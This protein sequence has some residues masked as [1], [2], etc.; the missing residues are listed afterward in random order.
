MVWTLAGEYRLPSP[1]PAFTVDLLA[2]ARMLDL[3][4][5]LGWNISGSLGPIDPAART[6]SA[7]VKD[8]V[9][10]ALIGVKGRYVFGGN[11]QWAVPFYLDVGT[12][13]SDSTMQAATGISYAFQWGEL[14]ALWRYLRYNMKSGQAIN[15]VYFSGPQIG[16]VFRW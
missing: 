5:K 15:D 4:Q 13:E 2:G 7:E 10:D 1:D 11:R 16:V 14:N 6:G 9:W 3:K 8:K 12:G